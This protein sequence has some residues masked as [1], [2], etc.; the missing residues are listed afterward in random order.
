[1]LD[2]DP[3]QIGRKTEIIVDVNV[4]CVTFV[5]IDCRKWRLGVPNVERSPVSTV[6]EVSAYD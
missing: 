5:G 2:S 1:M 4:H 6:C 3:M